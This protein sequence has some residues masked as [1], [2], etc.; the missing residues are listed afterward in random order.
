MTSVLLPMEALPLSVESIDCGEV[1]LTAGA[2][3]TP[4]L[5]LLSGIG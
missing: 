5:L 3:A 1:V 4:Q 2:I